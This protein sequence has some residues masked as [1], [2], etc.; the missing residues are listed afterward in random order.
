MQELII[1]EKPSAAKK[2][3]EALS[4]GKPIQETVDGV[5]IYDVTFEGKD[6]KIVSAV[7]HLFTV[8]EKVKSF[9]YPSFDIHWAPLFEV[10][11]KAAFSKKYYNAIKK[12]A[13]KSTSFTVAC[14]YDIEGEVIGLNVIKYICGQKDASRMKVSTL[15]KEDVI[16]AYKHKQKTL[17][18]GQA[19][20]GEARHFLDWMY[21]INLSRALT[22][23]VK[24]A[25]SFK[26]LSSGR[27]QG[28]ALKI[29]VDK[30]KEIKAFKPEP[31]WQITLKAL[32][33]KKVIEAVHEKDKIWKKPDAENIYAKIKDEKTVKVDEITRKKFKQ[34][35]PNPFDLGALQ[36]E[37]YKVFGMAP[38]K[39][40][41]IAQSLYLQGLTSYPRTS[42]QQLPANLGFKKIL[43]G[44]KKVPEYKENANY[45]LGLKTLKPNEGKKTDPAHPAIYPTGLI[46]K[47]DEPDEKK[48]YDLI[49]KR[50]MATFGEDAVRE[51]ATIKLNVKEEIFNA[52][53]TITTEKGWHTLYEPYVKLSE[54]EVPDLK[55]GEALKTKKIDLLSKQTLP[56]KRYTPA[57]I[58]AEL[59]KRGL[60][61]KAT[62]AD[63]VESLYDRGYINDK[64][65]E[66]TDLGIRIDAILE[67][68]CP[69]ITDEEFTRKIEDEMEKIRENKIKPE[70]VIAH[71][72]IDLTKVLDKIKKQ[73]QEIGLE[74]IEANKETRDALNALGPCPVCKEGVVMIRRGKFG[75]F[76]ACNRYPDCKTTYNLPKNALVKP[77]DKISPKG[78]PMILVIR[79]GKQPSELSLNP[80]ENNANVSEEHK[81]QM[82]SMK[83]GKLEKA[84]PQC[85]SPLTVRSSIYGE[86]IACTN[87]PKCKYT[88]NNK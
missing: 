46:G 68:H 3:A 27:V 85:G 11:K 54:D 14:D 35:P 61:T 4:S 75:M 32:K 84:C 31:Y 64:S 24:K 73:E 66:A 78:Y 51:T 58:I 30:E 5:T 63:I 18:W 25:G 16:E 52:K 41:Q 69:E 29:I 9:K 81:N 2:I 49:V 60:G 83:N 65:I 48:V 67:K 17:D 53:G 79:K 26:I 6:I 80:E 8:A 44:L 12:V 10:D 39:T 33:D 36:A 57:S 76:A 43:E 42:S 13:K 21:G 47:I 15:V 62:R 77:A 74:L 72:K 45:L 59:E 40:L 37:S 23:A 70:Q 55:K 7:G 38:K 86:F 28:P 34:A 88:E 71:A 50:F 1:T 82:D 87:Y 20:A 56:P 19:F 22:L